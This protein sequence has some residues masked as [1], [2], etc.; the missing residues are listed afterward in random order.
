M[1]HSS[2]HL[3]LSLVNPSNTLDQLTVMIDFQSSSSNICTD[4]EK[5]DEQTMGSL[6]P[7]NQVA[8]RRAEPDEERAADSSVVTGGS[9]PPD[10]FPV[11]LDEPNEEITE[12]W[13]DDLHEW[14][15]TEFVRVSN[16]VSSPPTQTARYRRNMS[17]TP[18]VPQKTLVSCFH[19][20]HQLFLCVPHLF[21]LPTPR[22]VDSSNR[23]H[24]PATSGVTEN[25]SSVVGKIATT[26]RMM[27]WYL[28]MVG[29]TFCLDVLCMRRMERMPVRP[30]LRLWIPSTSMPGTVVDI[31]E[32]RIQ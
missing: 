22:K 32:Q 29:M 11:S 2:G 14:S 21:G 27:F 9:D 6:Q 16:A 15:S 31:L 8:D 24:I 3:L 5:R 7:R 17:V 28:L 10:D 4:F 13:H 25:G 26:T 20:S 1:L 30:I 18:T 12:Q 19:R 23:T